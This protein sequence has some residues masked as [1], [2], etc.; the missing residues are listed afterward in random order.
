VANKNTNY[1]RI[2]LLIF[3]GVIVY[4]GITFVNQQSLLSSQLSKQN[5]LLAKQTEINQQIATSQDQL[6]YIGSDSYVIK[7]ARERL[8]WMFGDETKYV[9]VAPTNAGGQQ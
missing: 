9:E 1:K 4:A 2:K 7:E 5:E 6:S 3:F 8:G